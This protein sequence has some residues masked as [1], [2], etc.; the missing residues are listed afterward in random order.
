MHPLQ[1]RHTAASDRHIS[2]ENIMKKSFLGLLMIGFVSLA[3]SVFY[4]TSGKVKRI[5][6]EQD[7]KI[8]FQL[9][10]DCKTGTHYW[11]LDYQ[12]ATDFSTD[13]GLKNSYALL[14]WAAA[15]DKSIRV[16]TNSNPNSNCS[17]A[18]Q[19]A[20]YIYVNLP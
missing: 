20:D 9:E 16:V 15:N 17:D 3:F 5:Y 6:P 8:Y 19:K 2:G 11:Y 4:D 1:R 18:T 13:Q 14:L 7:G 10:G 12:H